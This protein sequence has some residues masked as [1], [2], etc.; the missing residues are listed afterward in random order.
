[1]YH[2]RAFFVKFNGIAGM[3]YSYNLLDFNETYKLSLKRCGNSIADPILSRE[4]EISLDALNYAYIALLTAKTS[5]TF[6][7]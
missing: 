7:Q 3:G 4:R 1:M 5:S 2:Q 6:I